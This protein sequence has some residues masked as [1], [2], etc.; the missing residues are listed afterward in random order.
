MSSPFR[1]IEYERTNVRYKF[2]HRR[3]KVR[4]IRCHNYKLCENIVSRR[5]VEINGN[6]ICMICNLFGWGK[7]V[8][9]EE[10]EQQCGVCLEKT[11]I[12]LK[13]PADGCSHFICV[14][15]S[16]EILFWDESLFQ[17]SPEPFGCPPCP[18][19]CYNPVRGYQCS[20]E[21]YVSMDDPENNPSVIEKWKKE[22]P[23]QYK[24]WNENQ[25]F[26][27]ELGSDTYSLRSNKRCPFCRKQYEP[28]LFI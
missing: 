17:L 26:S 24:E 10:P 18:N 19:G 13:F 5:H 8:F 22:E 27:V 20:C 12:H 11:P 15:C 14:K 25:E 2:N 1:D 3:M 9:K 23:E 6:Y 4:G 7:L 16:R 21:T 28:P